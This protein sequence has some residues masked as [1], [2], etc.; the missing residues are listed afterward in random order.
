[1]RYKLDYKYGQ[2]LTVYTMN[3]DAANDVKAIAAFCD[4]LVNRAAITDAT[5]YKEDSTWIS[6]WKP[7]SDPDLLLATIRDFGKTAAVNDV[8]PPTPHKHAALI[9]AWADGA[10][11]QYQSVTARLW[12][13]CHENNPGWTENTAYRI[14][15]QNMVTFHP[16]LSSGKTLDGYGDVGSM[17]P[18]TKPYIRVEINPDTMEL[19]SAT[20][21]KP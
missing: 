16:V 20:M 4:V 15:P 11:I 10:V 3:V 2:Y 7:I 12:H 1:M 21:V 6:G 18:Y 14:K 17:E 19:V 13:D 5:M 8:N 9:K